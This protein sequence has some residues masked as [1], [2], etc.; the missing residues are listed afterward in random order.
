MKIKTLIVDDEP[1]AIEVIEK[2]A[3]NF[4]ELEIVAKCS[5]AIDAFKILQQEKVDLLFLD[6]K[7]PGLKGTDFI[8]SL[9]NPPKVIFTT[10]Y[11][12]LPWKHSILTL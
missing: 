7:M 9:K 12:D 4:K 11:H 8:R 1:H 5:N 6:I 2:Y 3:Q 10:A